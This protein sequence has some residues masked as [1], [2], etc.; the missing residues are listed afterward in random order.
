MLS[1]SAQLSTEIAALARRALASGVTGASARE[2]RSRLRR[3]LVYMRYG[4]LDAVLRDLDLCAGMKVVDFSSPQ[5]LTMT[6][7]SRHPDI[8]FLYTNIID[9]ELTQYVEIAQALDLKNIRFLRLDIRQINFPDSTFDRAISVSVIEHV[10]PEVG[11]DAAALGEVYRVLKNGGKLLL[12]VPYKRKRNV[13]YVSGAV[14]ERGSRDR[15]FYA[16]EYDEQQL[17]ELL[18]RTQFSR[19]KPWFVCERSGWLALDEIEWG[20][21][22]GMLSARVSILIRRLVEK[23]GRTSFDASLAT[24]YLTVAEKPNGRLVNIAISLT[25]T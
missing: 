24:R 4:E 22:R 12:T 17:N 2:A 14:Y 18:D 21:R 16:R 20:P 8:E 5:W 1:L 25:K 11:G 13:V 10:Y 23:L 7:A 19:N 9:A 3:P 6:L 15:N